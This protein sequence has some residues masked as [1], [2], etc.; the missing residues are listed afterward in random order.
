MNRDGLRG[1]KGRTQCLDRFPCTR[2]ALWPLVSSLFR[3]LSRPIYSC[4]ELRAGLWN[5]LSHF[6]RLFAKSPASIRQPS[7]L[8]P[9]RKDMTMSYRYNGGRNNNHKIS[10]SVLCI[11]LTLVLGLFLRLFSCHPRSCMFCRCSSVRTQTLF[12]CIRR[13]NGPRSFS[14]PC[15]KSPTV[16]IPRRTCERSESCG[17]SPAP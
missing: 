4:L 6:C 15:R 1:S 10:F 11:M 8:Q 2:R 14:P 17:E 7:F 3:F 16:S 12:R 13:R 9:E 5:Q